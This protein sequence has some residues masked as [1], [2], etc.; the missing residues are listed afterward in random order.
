MQERLEEV[1]ITDDDALYGTLDA[2]SPLENSEEPLI[3]ENQPESSEDAPLIA[4]PI[5]GIPIQTEQPSTDTSSIYPIIESPPS[6]PTRYFVA[7][8][9]TIESLSR[10]HRECSI[11]ILGPTE[12]FATALSSSP[13]TLFLTVEGSRYYQGCAMI[14]L[15][16]NE[17]QETFL[18]LNWQE[19]CM[20]SFDT[21]ESVL[22]ALDANRRINAANDGAEVDTE[23]AMKLLQLLQSAEKESLESLLVKLQKTN[24]RTLQSES[25]PPPP[26]KRKV[27]APKQIQQLPRGPH[28]PVPFDITNMSYEEYLEAYH[29]HNMVQYQEMMAQKQMEMMMAGP[30]MAGGMGMMPMQMQQGGGRGGGGG[31]RGQ[32]GMGNRF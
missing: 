27:D 21:S 30:M 4:E 28:Q 1:Q 24:A 10:L 8:V 23:G 29:R 16:K 22:N 26:R 3:D 13:V 19:F 2:P 31:F 25:E 18:H 7:R 14:S 6:G 32:R 9:S 15:A 11:P 12:K 5:D 20:L 17:Q